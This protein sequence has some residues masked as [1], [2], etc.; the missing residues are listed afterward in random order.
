MPIF[1]EQYRYEETGQNSHKGM[2]IIR[3]LPHETL[4]NKQQISLTRP[5]LPQVQRELISYLKKRSI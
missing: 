4:H 3:V 1:R 2:L 5:S